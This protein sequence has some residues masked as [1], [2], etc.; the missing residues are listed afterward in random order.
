MVKRLLFISLLILPLAGKTQNHPKLIL[1]PQTVSA[2]RAN[3]GQV[4]LFDQSLYKIKQEVDA[5]IE[6]GIDVPVPKDMAGGYTHE[7]H[8]QNFFILQ[9]AGSL[10][11]ITG[12]EKY[13]VYIRDVLLAYAALYPSL[14]I[15]PT[16]RSYA[17]G[18]LFWQC[19]NDANW[20]VYVSQAYDC[21]YD[22]LTAAQ[23]QK[24]EKE[25]FRPFADF[26][27]VDNPQFFDRIHNHSTWGNAAVGMIGIVMDDEELIERALYG[28][29]GKKS[30]KNQYD[31]DGGLIELPNQKASGFL[32]QIDH[33]FSPDGYY[34]E[35]PYYQRY[36]IFPFMVFARSLAMNKPSLNI[37]AYRDSLLTRS[38]YALLQQTNAAGEFFPINDAQKGMSYLSRELVTAVD[39]AYA[40]GGQDPQLL[41]VAQDQGKVLLDETGFAVAKGLQEGKQKP[42]VK[43]SLELRDGAKGDEGA[44]GILRSGPMGLVMKYTAQGLGHG[45]YDKL[46]FSL[47]E[48]EKEVIQDYGAARWVNIDQKAGG[49]YLKENKSWAKQSIAHNT[50]VVDGTSHFGGVFKTANA[51]HSEPYAFKTDVNGLHIMSAKEKNAY[52]G[53]EMHRTMAL[54]SDPL[55]DRPLVIDVFRVESEAPHQYDLPWYF[56][57]HLLKADFPFSVEEHLVAMGEKHGYQ[58][59]F[60]EGKGKA[61]EGI[62]SI[63]WFGQQGFYSLHC[64]TDSATEMLFGR[65]G[66]NDPHFNLRRDPAFILRKSDQ[67]DAL[68][69]SL[70]ESHGSYSPVDEIPHNPFGSISEI[71]IVHQSAAYSVIEF[72]HQSGKRW[73][74]GIANQTPTGAHQVQIQDGQLEWEGPFYFENLTDRK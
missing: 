44:L 3:L 29:K 60:L 12:E 64:Q 61:N 74:L 14:P 39:I 40:L 36:A 59:L 45:H 34:T 7:R 38:V 73:R 21:I 35:G 54:L 4:P 24:L 27:S 43:H 31:N 1:Q 32:A 63:D 56:Q 16:D 13:A 58:H 19:L 66:A 17:T 23:R 65:V 15:H 70:L 53:M 52:P 25:L 47:Y 2:I 8:K 62:S 55:F 9:K 30:L 67:A 68:F 57:G 28:L 71:S 37:L 22:W 20:L 11:Q 42:F 18:K 33:A 26:L 5:E 69:V 72:Q 49:R 51:H 50:L 48:G 10:Y 46:S 41:S 6:K